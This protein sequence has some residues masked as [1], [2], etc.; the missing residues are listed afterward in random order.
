[1]PTLD[2]ALFDWTDYEDLKP[3]VWPS[4]KKKGTSTL[5]APSLTYSGGGAGHGVRPGTGTPAGKA[6][7]ESL[8]RAKCLLCINLLSPKKK[9]VRSA[10]LLIP[11]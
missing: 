2:M 3:E 8:S 4:A 9:K 6:A 5:L 1:M 7:V 10:L 11:L